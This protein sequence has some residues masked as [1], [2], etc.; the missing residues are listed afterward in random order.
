MGV[1]G[2]HGGFVAAVLLRATAKNVTDPS[3][4]AL[5]LDV[6][7][8]ATTQPAEAVLITTIERTGRSVTTVSARLIQDS[9]PAALAVASFGRPRQEHAK[10]CDLSLPVETSPESAPVVDRNALG[11]APWADNFEMRPCLG[12][13]PF[14]SSATALSGGWIRLLEDRP[15]DAVLLAALPDAWMPS[16]RTRLQ[17]SHGADS[18]IKIGLHFSGRGAMSTL[19]RNGHCFVESQAHIA[20][21]GYWQEDVTVWSRTGSVLVRSRQVAIGA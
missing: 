11:L 3:F 20:Q 18:T 14:G 4:E 21:S 9:R 19:D 1:G 5:T 12:G 10:F 7:Y 13:V 16:I 2:L 15:I 17:K 6:T 8:L